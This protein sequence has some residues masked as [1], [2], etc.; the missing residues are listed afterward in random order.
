MQTSIETMFFKE[1]RLSLRVAIR[2]ALT[3]AAG[4]L[5]ANGKHFFS[6][7]GRQNFL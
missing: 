1:L 5:P 6:H 7:L 2:M 3:H 4:V